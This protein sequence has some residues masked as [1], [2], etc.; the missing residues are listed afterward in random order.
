MEENKKDD[1]APWNPFE[2]IKL[3]RNIDD[4][5]SRLDTCAELLWSIREQ[6]QPN[7]YREIYKHL[8]KIEGSLSQIEDKL[9]RLAEG[10]YS[11]GFLFSRTLA[12]L[13]VIGFLVA[14]GI[15]VLVFK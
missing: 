7:N 14:F 1:T 2:D 3:D 12:I 6:H 15:L 11:I 10:I 8:S 4:L 13:R 5:M 9:N